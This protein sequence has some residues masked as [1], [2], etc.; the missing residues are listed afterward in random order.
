MVS[1]SALR[2]LT[3]FYSSLDLAG[4]RLGGDVSVALQAGIGLQGRSALPALLPLL[5]GLSSTRAVSLF[6][7][8]AL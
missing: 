8:T 6:P 1:V 3:R 2:T 4:S 5:Q 7:G